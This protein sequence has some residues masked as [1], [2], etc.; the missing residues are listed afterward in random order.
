MA[1]YASAALKL[2]EQKKAPVVMIFSCQWSEYSGLDDPERVLN[3][4]NAVVQE[5]PCFKSLDPVHV[6][7]ALNNGFDGVMGVVCASEDCKLTEGRD[8]AERQLG[9]LTNA[10]AKLNLSDRFQLVEL[11]PRCE[12]EFKN[13]FA[14]FYQKIA[15]MS[16]CTVATNSEAKA[17]TKS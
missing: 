12:G 5:V 11:S 10:L 1:R 17:C 4:K 2:K 14:A 8:V 7:N 6:I 9:V 15:A 3:G 16:P 13:K